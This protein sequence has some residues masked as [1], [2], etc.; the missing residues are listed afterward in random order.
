M[1]SFLFIKSPYSCSFIRFGSDHVD[2]GQLVKTAADRAER[3]FPG[4]FDLRVHVGDTVREG[5]CF[6]V[7]NF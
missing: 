3:I 7:G 1:H 6:S 4:G 5:H 2:R